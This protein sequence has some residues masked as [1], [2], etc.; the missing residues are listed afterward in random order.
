MTMR[1][2]GQ[3]VWK[4]GVL[5]GW[6]H[7]AEGRYQAHSAVLRRRRNDARSHIS[8]AYEKRRE[9][10]LMICCGFSILRAEPAGQTVFGIIDPAD[11][12]R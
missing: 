9:I 1:A 8:R 10:E 11:C 2:D 5:S 12:F 6:Q 4:S 7:C 3:N